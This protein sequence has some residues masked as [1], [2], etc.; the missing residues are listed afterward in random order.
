MGRGSEGGGE[1][2]EWLGLGCGGGN[3]VGVS[4]DWGGGRGF[5]RNAM[6]GVF[7][8]AIVIEFSL[9]QVE[10]MFS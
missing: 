6:R 8:K 1:G 4:R 7:I 3:Q 10:I 5:P 2:S 9:L